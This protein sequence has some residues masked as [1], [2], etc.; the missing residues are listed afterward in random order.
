METEAVSAGTLRD[1]W[2]TAVVLA[3]RTEV[4]EAQAF[5]LTGR[6]APRWEEGLAAA[7]AV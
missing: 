1:P 6:L 4:E 5:P 2:K 7:A 3:E